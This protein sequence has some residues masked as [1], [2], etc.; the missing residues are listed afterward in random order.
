VV[1]L[2]GPDRSPEAVGLNSRKCLFESSS[3]TDRMP[4]IAAEAEQRAASD[5]FRAQRNVD[6]FG[7]FVPLLRSPE[8]M[9]RLQQV[10]IH[11]RY[12]SAMGLRLTEFAILMVARRWNQKVEW[13]IHAPVAAE[14]G[15]APATIAALLAGERPVVL[16]ED[17]ALVFDSV[18]ELWSTDCWTDAMYA[19]MT[20]RFGDRGVI[21]LI[22]TIGYYATIAQVMNV[23]RTEAPGGFSMPELPQGSAFIV[24]R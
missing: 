4:P 18:C 1:A 19:T 8:L 17:E 5:A 6:V 14:A 24:A 2:S 11:C 22:G 7:P 21:D 23:A 3:M 12:N 16:A 9:L 13:A 10:G 15:V 20:K